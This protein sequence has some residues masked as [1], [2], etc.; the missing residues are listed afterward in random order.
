MLLRTRDLNTF[1]VTA[2]ALVRLLRSAG[3]LIGI[4]VLSWFQRCGHVPVALLGGATGR[5]GDPSGK[6]AER[7]ELDEAALVRN[8]AGIR[9][10]LAA[11]LGHGGD[12]AQA[13]ILDNYDW[14]RD[15]SLLSFLR[16]VGRHARVG[17][18]MAKESVRKR[19]QSDTG[20]SYTEFTYQLLQGYDFVHLFR[21]HGVSVQIGGSDQW[22]NITAGTD[23]LRRLLQVNSGYGL[24]FPLLLKSD[25]SKFGK[26]EDGAVW[27][28]PALLSPYRFYQYMF[29]TPDS[30]VIKFMKMLTFMDLDEI[31][32]YERDMVAAGYLPNKA[33][34][35]L[36][37]EVTMFVHGQAGLKE[38]QR[39][40][41]ALA[42]GAATQLDFAALEAIAADVPS[43]SLP[44][45]SVKDC[46]IVNLAVLT[47]LFPSKGAARR[48]IQQGGVYLNNEKVDGDARIVTERDILEGKMLLLAAGKKN[49]MLVKVS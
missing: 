33:Q 49:K 47:N 8:V 42:P 26:S 7:P 10:T 23:L 5:V 29:N 14:W 2:N 41:S 20:M 25:G 28:S 37:D 6:S 35:R 46:N 15:V 17:V 4:I 30:D 19:L 13:V 18:M 39:A 31:A 22:G 27:L 11:V 44:L 21:E 12:A 1:I 24:T 48:L 34:R 36:A 16:D 32:Q 9:A 3:N 40:T 43:I 38:A 45:A